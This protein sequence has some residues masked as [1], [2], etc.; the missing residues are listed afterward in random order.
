MS[1]IG[2]VEKIAATDLTDCGEGFVPGLA[3]GPAGSD[4]HQHTPPEVTRDLAPDSGSAT[5][6]V[7]IW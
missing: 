7:P 1:D 4:D 6:P 2:T 5:S 3:K